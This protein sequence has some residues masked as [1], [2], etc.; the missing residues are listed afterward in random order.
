MESA[1]TFNGRG[2]EEWQLK[3][4]TLQIS[5]PDAKTNYIDVP[6]SN[7]SLDMRG[8]DKP[9]VYDKNKNL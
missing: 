9:L 3:L 8:L 2:C 4:V 5:L 1:I 6:G 7:G